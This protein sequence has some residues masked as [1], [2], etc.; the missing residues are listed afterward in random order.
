MPKAE[1]GHGG[2]D[3]RM[4]DD[5]FIGGTDDPL[6]RAA[7]HMDGTWAIMTG[8]AANRS[9]QTGQVVRVDDLVRGAC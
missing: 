8:I 6:G 7:D 2:G 9:F 4:L 1:G 3:T 5:I